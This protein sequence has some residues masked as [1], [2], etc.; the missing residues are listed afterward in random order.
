MPVDAFVVGDQGL[1]PAMEDRHVLMVD[2]ERIDGAIFDGHNGS[3]VA[4]LAADMYPQVAS[5]EPGQALRKIHA[6]CDR[7]S[8]GACAV[9]FRLEGNR[10]RV[11]NAGDADLA[12]VREGKVEVLTERHRLDNPAELRRLLAAGAMLQPPYVLNPLTLDGLMPTRA[13]GDHEFAE[14]GISAEPYEWVGNFEAGWLVAA[15]DGLWDVLDPAELPGYLEGDA[16]STAQQLVHE[17]LEVRGSDDNV[18][19]MVIKVR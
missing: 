1:R 13:L 4:Q 10:L 12:V 17:A 18:T 2:G 6:S 16:R 11:A 19:V 15:C 5:L 14:A 8:G 9:A 7:L 3:D